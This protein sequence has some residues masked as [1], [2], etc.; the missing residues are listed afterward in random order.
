MQDIVP[1]TRALISVSD[2]KNLL[3]LAEYLSRRGVE[4]LS[5]GGTASLLEER[6]L[7]VVQVS[8][9]TGYPEIFGGRVKT[10]H[11]KVH[12]GLLYRRE[13]DEDVAT[14]KTQGIKPIDLLVVN[15]YPFKKTLESGAGHEEVVENIDVGGPAMI[16]AAAKNHAYV[17]VVVEP[18]RYRNLMD[19]ITK[20]GGVTLRW[21]EIMAATA[22]AHTCAY[23]A[24]IAKYFRGYTDKYLDPEPVNVPSLSERRR[25]SRETYGND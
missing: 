2:K 9:Y 15:L 5:T 20:N 24:A 1:V 10:L 18:H 8:D 23:D 25:E 17:A 13:N 19:H 4:L 12:G 7:P 6:G 3:G 22:Y 14:A 21:R 11:P 16:R